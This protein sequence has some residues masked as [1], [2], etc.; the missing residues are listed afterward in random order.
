MVIK[1]A[2]DFAS[3]EPETFAIEVKCLPLSQYTAFE[4]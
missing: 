1:T 3:L 2:L 4:Y